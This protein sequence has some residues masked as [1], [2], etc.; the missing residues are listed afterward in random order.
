MKKLSILLMFVAVASFVFVGC[1]KYDDGPTLSFAS[2][3]GRVVNTWKVEKEIYNGVEQTLDPNDD[4]SIEFK[5][6]DSFTVSGTSSGVTYSFTGT[7]KFGDKKETIITTMGSDVDTMVIT[8]L[9]SKELWVK[10]VDG[11]SESHYAKK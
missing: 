8:R 2:K 5:R 3:K 9:K 6:D 1:K 4:S 7:W 10:S 11:K